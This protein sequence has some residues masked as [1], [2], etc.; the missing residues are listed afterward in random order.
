[1]LRNM[2]LIVTYFIRSDS[3]IAARCKTCALTFISQPVV[4]NREE[5]V[6][7]Y[8]NFMYYNISMARCH[9]DT[10]FQ[11]YV[12]R[13]HLGSS[14]DMP[15]FDMLCNLAEIKMLPQQQQQSFIRL[16]VG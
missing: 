5:S 13:R 3:S 7:G 1:M 14:F 16:Q 11:C 12:Q 9:N 8:I 10:R 15:S 2:L 4:S 6:L